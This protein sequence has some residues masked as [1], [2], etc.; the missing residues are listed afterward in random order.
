MNSITSSNP[1]SLFFVNICFHPTTLTFHV[2]TQSR[3]RTGPFFHFW[4]E[5]SWSSMWRNSILWDA[6]IWW[7]AWVVERKTTW[8]PTRRVLIISGMSTPR[9][10]STKVKSKKKTYR[11]MSFWLQIKYFRRHA[12]ATEHYALTI[13]QTW[14]KDNLG[15]RQLD[16]EIVPCDNRLK[17][18]AN[19]I[20]P[21]HVNA[22]IEL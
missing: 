11:E 22:T 1:A 8:L 17:W 14:S 7:S 4:W 2:M 13:Y 3:K 6:T 16:Q 10:H 20:S 19:C 18:S 21:F 15:K 12:R 9:T 5:Y